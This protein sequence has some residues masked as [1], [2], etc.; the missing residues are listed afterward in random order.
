MGNFVGKHSEKT[1]SQ[2]R[3]LTLN[4]L[5]LIACYQCRQLCN[6]NLYNKTE[7]NIFH[8][9]SRYAFYPN[10]AFMKNHPSLIIDNDGLTVKSNKKTKYATIKFGEFLNSSHKFI[11]RVTFKMDIKYAYTG[12]GFIKP[13]FNEWSNDRWNMGNWR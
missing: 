5:Y 1:I 6:Q 10:F 12:F 2:K 9:I 8:L 3:I 13:T 4:D 11:Y 7:D